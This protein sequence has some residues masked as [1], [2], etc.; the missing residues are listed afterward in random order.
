MLTL[1]SVQINPQ[2]DFYGLI[3]TCKMRQ[4]S[5]KLASPTYNK[6]MF[7]LNHIQYLQYLDI[8][9]FTYNHSY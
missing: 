3:S 2:L 9:W 6:N 8:L 4:N 7:F 1:K 5:L